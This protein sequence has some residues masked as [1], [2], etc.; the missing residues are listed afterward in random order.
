MAPS[1]HLKTSP[2]SLDSLQGSL[3]YA[4]V[5]RLMREDKDRELTED[6]YCVIEMQ[7]LPDQLRHYLNLP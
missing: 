2:E 5:E 4:D 7:A 6:R 1:K 3:A